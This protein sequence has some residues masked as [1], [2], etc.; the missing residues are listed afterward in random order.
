MKKIGFIG[1]GNMGDAIIGALL[2]ADIVEKENIFVSDIN[3]E[4]LD[5]KNQNIKL[6]LQATIILF[7]L[8]VM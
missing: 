8:N 6:I 1:G 7:F 4:L 3:K 2:K 5:L